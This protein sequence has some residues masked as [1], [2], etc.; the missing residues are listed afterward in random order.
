M[1]KKLTPEQ[2]ALVDELEQQREDFYQLAKTKRSQMIK[3][4]QKYCKLQNAHE[5]FVDRHDKL[6][7]KIFMMVQGVRQIESADKKARIV[8]KKNS[9]ASIANIIG[10]QAMAKMLK[11]LIAKKKAKDVT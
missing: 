6:D 10:D 11:D 9:G 3:A 5:H 7:L 1:A 4:Y 8:V 2:Q